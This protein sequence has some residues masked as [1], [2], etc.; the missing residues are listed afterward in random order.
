MDLAILYVNSKD[1]D[2]KYVKEAAS[3]ASSFRAHLPDAK[4]YLY[5]NMEVPSELAGQFDHVVQCDFHVP[6]FLQGRVHLNG[7]MIV[8]H[9]AM[10]ELQEGSVMYL[11]ADTYALRDVVS[12]LPEV[13]DRF[14]IA[15]AHAPVRINTELGN[16]DIPEVP[17][18]FPE[19]NCDLILYR[20]NAEVR[21]FLRTWQRS[22]LEDQFAHPHDQGTFRYHLYTSGLRVCTLP[23]E[24]NYR[25][26]AFREDTVILQNRYALDQ[27]IAA[28]EGVFRKFAKRLFR[29]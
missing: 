8:K 22:Y 25:G 21:E 11:G 9:A 7:Q 20:N 15:A 14:D 13:L 2:G 3:S 5:S 17:K 28:D 19:L 10:L 23:P 18:A 27:Y 4:Y 16:S 29:G 26:R 1:A 24:Y 12:E 6:E